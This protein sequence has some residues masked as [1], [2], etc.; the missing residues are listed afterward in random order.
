M[1]IDIDIVQV[2]NGIYNVAI[3]K[4]DE[5]IGP[6]IACGHEWD[7]WMR[8]DIKNNYKDGTDIIDIGAN[9]GYNTLMFSDYGPVHTFEPVY[10]EIVNINV[11]NNVLKNNVFIYSYALSDVEGD[12]SMYI[13]ERGCQTETKIN[14]GGTSMTMHE[15]LGNQ[16]IDVRC[17]RLDDI[18]TCTPSIIKIYVEG[19]ELQ[20][21]KGAQNIIKTHMPMI[22]VEIH[23]YENSNI[24]SY[25]ES[26]G[27][28]TPERRPE[29]MFLYRAKDIFSTI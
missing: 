17:K 19:H 24:P 9:I 1:S 10:Y 5:Y 13:P 22:L 11:K 6:C 15:S 8:E 7:G 23:D 2:N 21:I 16:K 27:Y 4:N 12:T 25:L 18:Y 3:I 26:M 29:A 28:G 20:T 14:Y